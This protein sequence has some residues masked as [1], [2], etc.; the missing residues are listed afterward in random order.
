LRLDLVRERRYFVDHPLMLV[1]GHAMGAG[2][3]G[4]VACGSVATGHDCCDLAV[5]LLKFSAQV[6]ALS[7]DVIRLTDDFVIVRA[8]SGCVLLRFG[9]AVLCFLERHAEAVAFLFGSVLGLDEL[10]AGLLVQ[11]AKP[12]ELACH[13]VDV[14]AALGGFVAGLLQW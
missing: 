8:P 7:L 9:G 14:L 13:V 5:G 11:S 2:T 10:G 1:V 3:G 4:A 6:V 12:V